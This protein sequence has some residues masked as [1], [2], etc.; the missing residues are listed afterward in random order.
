MNEDDLTPEERAAIRALHR[1]AKTWP[2]TL[3]LFTNGL[4]LSVMRCSPSG[5]RVM[6][7]DGSVDQTKTVDVVYDIP[8]DGGDW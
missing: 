4:G 1:L 5:E 6:T 7:S 8:C 3:W 2:S